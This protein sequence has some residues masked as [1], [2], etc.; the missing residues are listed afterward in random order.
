MLAPALCLSQ[1]GWCS[2]AFLHRATPADRTPG[3]S[4]RRGA[5]ISRPE[6]DLAESPCLPVSRLCREDTEH[7][8]SPVRRKGAST[9]LLRQSLCGAA[10]RKSPE[11][12][13]PQHCPAWPISSAISL[14]RPNPS[15]LPVPSGTSCPKVIR[16]Q[17]FPA[18][19]A[20]WL[21]YM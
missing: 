11:K 10:C 15:E 6:Q 19:Q 5:A 7:P 2:S 4:G 3:C 1:S 18:L 14:P 21:P 20:D 9:S 17:H 12:T 8:C 16:L 13:E